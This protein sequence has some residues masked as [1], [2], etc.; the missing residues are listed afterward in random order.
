MFYLP[1]ETLLSG[2][3]YDSDFKY[4]YLDDLNKGK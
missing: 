3:K 1:D 2:L 4:T